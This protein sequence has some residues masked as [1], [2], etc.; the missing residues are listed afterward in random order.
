[1][2]EVIPGIE[3]GAHLRQHQAEHAHAERLGQIEILKGRRDMTR[4]L[5]APA[6]MLPA[7]QR[8]ETRELAGAER[9]LG[10][11]VGNNA[12]GCECL[13]RHF[14]HGR[15]ELEF[16]AHFRLEHHQ[17]AAAL[18][19]G[20]VERHVR[21]ALEAGGIPAMGRI[22][23]GPDAGAALQQA[24]AEIQ[25]LSH[26]A[27]QRLG[28]GEHLPVAGQ[29]GHDEG[30]LI[31]SQ[32][33]HRIALPP[34]RGQPLDESAQQEISSL[35]AQ[36]VVGLFQLVEIEQQQADLRLLLLGLRYGLVQAL[37]EQAAVGKAGEGIML[38]RPENALFRIF[39]VGDVS[40]GDDHA[41]CPAP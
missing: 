36:R 17:A 13:P 5:Y 19:L 16:R 33:R 38:C 11:I 29:A 31:P 39:L 6:R 32:P 27:E 40:G 12:V 24:A 7:Q 14:Q 10:L 37:D 41:P 1:M 2:A 15:H 20:A 9:H 3:P 22:D 23:A 25:R 34:D 26:A 35:V 30:E 4:P 8:L 28:Q 21:I 18:R